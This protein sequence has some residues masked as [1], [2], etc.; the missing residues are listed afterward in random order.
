[1]TNKLLTHLSLSLL[2]AL[3]ATTMLSIAAC[4]DDDPE[5]T[6]ERAGVNGSACKES[7]YNCKLRSSGGPRVTKLDGTDLWELYPNV[8]I[9]DGNG[10]VRLIDAAPAPTKF[11]WGQSRTFDGEPHAFA[12]TTANHGAGWVPISSIKERALFEAALGHV[13][14]KSA[15]L[16]ALGCYVVRNS[17]DP[18][19]EFKKVVEDSQVGAAGHERAGDYLPLERADGNRSV[20]LA[21]NVPGFS[22]GGVAIDHFPAGTKFQRVDVPTH[23]GRPSIDIR[24][25]VADE[26][27]HYLKQSGTM[28]FIYGYVIA[29]NG[30]KRSGW[31]AYDALTPCRGEPPPPDEDEMPTPGD[32]PQ[33]G[34][35][36]SEPSP[37]QCYVRC[38][39]DT[40]QGPADTPDTQ[41]CSDASHAMCV[42]HVKRI[43][44]NGIE[45]W[46]RPKACWAKC[47]NRAAYHEVENIT[48]DCTE[49][50][51]EFC[52]VGDRGA[53][54]DAMWSQCEPLV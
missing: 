26:G 29:P 3:G 45:V 12:M 22:L 24:L 27:G 31:M 53:F 36:S 14:A 10:E 13:S 48:Q 47:K 2:L 16:R 35:G 23:S 43:E 18:T 46:E 30:D 38:C 6:E 28:K 7:R 17:H 8:P 5:A 41:A 20:N 1:M 32:D 54:E 50:A 33:P 39:D 21:F 51:K 19:L 25:W 34:P 49:H 4:D 42:S 37:N 52:S 11:N 44:W 9:R 40:L 15:G